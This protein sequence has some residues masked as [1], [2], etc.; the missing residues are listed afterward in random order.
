MGACHCFSILHPDDLIH[1]WEQI[2]TVGNQQ[3]HIL[4]RLLFQICKN[5]LLRAFIQGRKRI[6]QNQHR[7]LI[8]KG[9]GKGKTFSLTAGKTYPAISNQS[10]YAVVHFLYFLIHANHFKEIFCIFL[11]SHK[12]VIFHAVIKQLW[13]MTK[14]AYDTRTL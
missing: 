12:N 3:N 7:L 2:Q 5:L 4:P 10:L 9:S 1:L 6:V 13:I 14:I 11:C 8:A